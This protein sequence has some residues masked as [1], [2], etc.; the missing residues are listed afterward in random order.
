MS[1]LWLAPIECA[2]ILG[3]VVTVLLLNHT[4]QAPGRHRM[5][6]KAMAQRELALTD[7][8][9]RAIRATAKSRHKMPVE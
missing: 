1:P 6:R 3:G 9:L 7:E 8:W 5:D 2:I 4:S